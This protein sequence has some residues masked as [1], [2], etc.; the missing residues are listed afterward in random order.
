MKQRLSSLFLALVMVLGMI[1]VLTPGAQAVSR[2]VAGG[3][4]SDRGNP[5]NVNAGGNYEIIMVDGYLIYMQDGSL[6]DN[7]HL[8]V[9]TY[10]P[11]F[12]L[13]SERELEIEL[14]EMGG[15]FF[16]EDYNFVVFGQDNF[17]ERSDVEVLRVVKYSKD[18]ERL[19]S[20]GL[21]RNTVTDVI[22]QWGNLAFAEY[23][24]MLYLH[25]GRA[26]N[27]LSDGAQHQTNMTFSIRQSDMTVTDTRLGITSLGTGYVSH[28]LTQ[29]ILVDRQGRLV[30]ADTGDAYPRG[31]YLFR[32]DL[33]AGGDTF[34][35]G[36]GEGVTFASW[37]GQGGHVTQYPT[38]AQ[39]T[40]LA[41]TDQGYLAAYIDTGR[42]SLGGT[43]YPYSAYLTFFDKDDPTQ[44]TTRT[45][46]S[47]PQYGGQSAWGVQLIP[48]SSS[49]GYVLWYTTQPDDNWVYPSAVSGD[50]HYYYTKYRA[51]GTFDTPVDLGVVPGAFAGPLYHNGQLVWADTRQ[52]ADKIRFCT[53]DDSGLTVHPVGESAAQPE[54]PAPD[55]NPDP[56]TSAA[57]QD[58]PSSHWA[59]PY[60][61]R[62]AQNGWGTGVG[63]GR[64]DPNAPLTFA[65]FYTMVTPIFQGENLAQYQ[66]DPGA[67]WWQKYMWV[68][69][70]YLRANTIWAETM[71]VG[72]PDMAP[73]PDQ[74]LQASIDQH[75]NEPITRTDA[76][77]ILWR[78]LG[79]WNA[80]DTVPG[81]EEARE[82]ILASGVQ[83]NLME[84]DTVPVCY[85]AGL[86][87]G[88]ETGDLN[89]NGTL[90][91]AEGCVLLCSLVDYASAHGI[92]M[93][94]T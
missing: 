94:G 93:S 17:D 66:P 76:I 79:E 59:Y 43:G 61:T 49:S 3:A 32:Y 71:Y 26:T 52:G 19:D 86:I 39:I 78:V 9:R 50:Y 82:A 8:M 41:E 53:L 30:T 60:I 12:Q 10:S 4:R 31:A 83:L 88:D 40:A 55:P 24:G 38:S 33:P 72:P 69:A 45:L 5:L 44:Y 84:W 68:G 85:A 34:Y 64:F 62:A 36:Q 6:E 37:P 42:G 51:D 91:R 35:N 18:W 16:G 23:N 22:G 80:N 77:S 46:Q 73:D 15:F 58:V 21:F 1:P 75:A 56:G 67:P 14:Q 47:W 25:S 57:F 20:A 27:T 7:R 89:L 28:A 48:T 90:T 11:Q 2:P 29:D 92:A 63:G 70:K 81:V 87:S 54:E 13:L 65:Q 74:E